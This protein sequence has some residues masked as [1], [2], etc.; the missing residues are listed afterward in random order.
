MCGQIDVSHETFWVKMNKVYDV[1]VVG[2]GHAGCEAAC[3]AARRGADT[4]L[5]TIK[6]E[7]IGRMSCNPSIGGL[8]KG[9]ITRE[10]D[11]LGGVMGQTIDKT[12]IHFRMLNRSKGPAVWAPRAQADRIK[13]QIEM[14]K[15]LENQDNLE[16][17]EAM[18]EELLVE[19]GQIRGVRTQYQ[20]DYLAHTVVLAP[21]TF[22]RGKIHIGLKNFSAGRAGEF[23]AESLSKSLEK[24]GFRLARFKT[25]T[26]P[27]L[28]SRTLDF[29]ELEEQHP[30]EP[31]PKFSYYTDIKPKNYVSCY[32]TVTNTRTHKIIVDN[33]KKSSLFSGNITG[34]GARYCPSIEDKIKK[35]PEKNHH[36]VFIE[37]EGTD[38]YEMYANGISTS[39][40]PDIQEKIVHSIRG[41]Q[42]AK[43]I[44]FGYAIEYDCV[45]SHYITPS[46]ETR[47]IQ[48]LFLAGQINGTSG[49]EEAACQ[50]LIAGI[51]AVNKL[52]KE[53]PLILGRDEAYIGVLIDDL[54]TKG[55]DE[56]YRMFTARAEYRL[57]LRQDNADQRL[58]PI[59]YKLGLVSSQ[60]FQKFLKAQEMK[61]RELHKLRRMT[62]KLGEKKS[63]KMINLLK[64]P[65]ITFD[66]LAKYGYPIESDLTESV[67][68]KIT[69]EIKYEG[70]LK[71]QMQE[72]EG[73]RRLEHKEIPQDFDYMEFSA[74]SYEAREKLVQFK[75]RSIGQ[76][77]RIPGV[78]SADI[79]ALLVKLKSMYG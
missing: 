38:T 47:N 50:G 15:I 71:R 58:M 64:R 65:E 29:S 73:F 48:G 16:I 26:P 10:I 20:G 13:Y 57:H 62:A 67:K 34:I 52:K 24:C 74:I 45:P 36:Q 3:A 23:A 11:A 8:A 14:R 6:L 27:R 32:L 61:K 4:L 59:G 66:D 35:F 2:A 39:F 19:N 30:D 5:F 79:S 51:N 22:M 60:R 78:T 76:A 9:H 7:S 63:C 46:L 28:D 44:R 41:L 18:V 37:P 31:P 49:Y 25:G 53:P 55:V 43:I 21:G 1:I 70:Y 69:L 72:I 77:T 75:P 54:V 40:P 42:N 56:P 33:L 12:G 68:G 17:K